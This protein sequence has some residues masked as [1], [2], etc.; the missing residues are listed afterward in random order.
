MRPAPDRPR[1][2]RASRRCSPASTS[3]RWSPS[4]RRGPPTSSTTTSRPRRRRRSPRPS[5]TTPTSWSPTWS[6]SASEVLVT[7]WIESPYSLAHVIRE[8]TQEERDHYGELFVRFLFAGPRRTGMLHADPH[9]GNFRILPDR[10]RRPRPARRPRLR[11]RRPAAE[12][13]LPAAMGRL[14]RDRRWRPTRSPWSPGC[15][16]EGFIK[17]NIEVD[18]QRWCSTTSRRSSSRPTV[19][20]FTF[21]REWMRDAVRADQ[22]P[23]RRDVHRW[24]PSSTCR[25]PTS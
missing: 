7:E 17:D 2:A 19:E 8:G 13:Q 18:P 23:A 12:R 9:P 15:A 5:A 10:G 20:R 24:R 21:T 22:Q 1:G 6:R 14:I 3:S 11:R 4:C 16:S 25:R